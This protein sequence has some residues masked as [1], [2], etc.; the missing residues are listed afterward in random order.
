MSRFDV[1]AFKK[2]RNDK[3]YAVRLGSATPRQDGEG[4]NVYLDA[5]PAPENGQFQFSIVPPRDQGERPARQDRGQQGPLDDRV[6]F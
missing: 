6:P 1:V 4:F 5:M 3:T 2:T